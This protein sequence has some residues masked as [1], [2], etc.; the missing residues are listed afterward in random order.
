MKD[1]DK[2]FILYENL[3]TKDISIKSLNN[4]YQIGFEKA[5]DLLSKE[6]HKLLDKLF[7]YSNRF[8]TGYIDSIVWYSFLATSNIVLPPTKE[9]YIYNSFSEIKDIDMSIQ[10][11][12][13]NINTNLSKKDFK[14]NNLYQMKKT[15][16][17]Q[18]SNKEN[19]N[20]DEFCLILQKTIFYHTDIDFLLGLLHSIFST[21]KRYYLKKCNSCGKY[22]ITN[23][24]D[25]CYCNRE[26]E[27]NNKSISCSSI[28]KS[29]KKSYAY[30]E[31]NKKHKSFL[32]KL[33]KNKLVSLEYIETYKREHKKKVEEYVKSRNISKLKDF[34]YTYEELHPFC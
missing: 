8:N 11:S 3:H 33:N 19:M 26:Y 17:F 1:Y 31:L 20:N 22:Y 34:I 25:N 29:L 23:K 27:Y 16:L 28:S 7:D 15:P 18:L 14:D 5:F 6:Q 4:K 32:Q 21:S 10:R 13:R 12:G 2:K 24:T 30:V 9:Q